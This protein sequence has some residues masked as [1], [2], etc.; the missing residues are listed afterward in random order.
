MNKQMR[1]WLTVY[2]NIYLFIYLFIYRSHMFQRQRAILRE[3][4]FGAC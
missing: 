4:L 3:L 1:I 2:D